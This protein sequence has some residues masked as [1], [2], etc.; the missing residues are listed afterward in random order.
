[1]DNITHS[2]FGL[3]LSRA[4]LGRLDPLATCTLVV[5]SNFPDVDCI[6]MLFEEKAWYLC[7]H[8]GITHAFLG[9]AFMA[10]AL[11]L[12]LTGIGRLFGTQ[13]SLFRLAGL[14]ALGML[15]HLALDSLN[16]YGVRPFLPFSDTWYYG[17]LAYI[18]DPWFLLTLSTAAALGCKARL[19]PTLLWWLLLGLGTW[20]MA[21]TGR[22]PTTVGVLW[23]SSLAAILLVRM[24]LPFEAK[25]GA[26]IARRAL[27]ASALYILCLFG[28]SR[29]ASEKGLALLQEQTK[30]TLR[31]PSAN[32]VAGIPWRYT[33]MAETDEEVLVLPRFDPFD[34]GRLTVDG[35]HLPMGRTP[36]NLDEPLL[37]S[38]SKNPQV[39]A[40]RGFAR[41]PYLLRKG[42]QF[43]LADRRYS[44]SGN[45]ES[46][47]NLSV[48]IPI[49]RT[50]SR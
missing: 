44:A 15:G 28:I 7:N 4:G 39:K 2:I 27:G 41:H 32:P 19:L 21:G 31:N 49:I 3:A 50:E 42:N 38:L 33:I 37:R 23:G 13:A 20:L 48:E 26:R 36:R 46:W 5:A 9:I 22:A 25:R 11:A 30:S 24:C 35:G 8:R 34:G 14:A 40:W 1:L 47:C 17:D 18:V 43:V 6:G 29:M 10:P 12:L 45:P 16:S